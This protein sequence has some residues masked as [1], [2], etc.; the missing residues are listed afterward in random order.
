MKLS[1]LFAI[2][3]L[4]TAL[5]SLLH[6]EVVDGIRAI[7]NDTVI[8]YSQVLDFTAPAIEALRQQYASEPDLFNQKAT[9][10]MNDGLEQLVE[11][12][13]ILQEFAAKYTK[14]PDSVVDGLVEDRI[15]DRFGD[16]V[17]LMKTLQA[18]GMTFEQFR[19]DIRDQYIESALRNQ[20]IQREIIISPYKVETYYLAHQDDFKLED[21]IKLRMIVLNKSGP[22]DTN[23][24]ALAHEILSRIKNGANFQEMAT[25]YSQG[26]QQ[27]QAGDWGWVERSVLRS[28][29]ADTAFSM[30]PG[31]VSNVIETPDSDYIM[32]VEDRR[33]AHVRPLT[34]V[35]DEIEKILRTQEQ[36]QL[37]KTWIDGLKKKTFIRYFS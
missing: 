23:T 37:E 26:S 28:E 2:F 33:A 21:Q 35:R 32:L 9:E 36:A 7:V 8:T 16:R 6:A 12:Q 10:T 15:R 19:E 24:L 13:L 31:Q 29:L 27:H 11:R 18:E 4:V 14:L 3:A 17:T 25:I 30:K 22:T 1:R 5:P 20:N 34:D